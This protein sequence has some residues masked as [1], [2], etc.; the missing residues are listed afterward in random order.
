MRLVTCAW[1]EGVRRARIFAIADVFDT[2]C[3]LQY[4][5]RIGHEFVDS[6]IN[7]RRLL[8]PG[9]QGLRFFGS[10]LLGPAL[11]KEFGLRISKA[12]WQPGAARHECFPFS[13]STAQ[14]GVD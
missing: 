12:E 13:I 3:L 14:D 8:I 7:G 6:H 5:M 4:L 1:I 10:E 11:D 9:T 2:G